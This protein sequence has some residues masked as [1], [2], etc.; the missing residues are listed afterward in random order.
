[1]SSCFGW[2]PT[3]RLSPAI[4]WPTVVA[5]RAM[6]IQTLH[7]VLEPGTELLVAVS[8]RPNELGNGLANLLVSDRCA[9]D[10]LA[11][12]GTLNAGSRVG[13]THGASGRAGEYP[14]FRT[15]PRP[16][17]AQEQRYRLPTTH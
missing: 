1:M 16:R 3:T 10:S 14:V 13:L 17:G 8:V 15:K 11:N 9:F 2:S 7:K 12:F 6:K 5:S 4:S